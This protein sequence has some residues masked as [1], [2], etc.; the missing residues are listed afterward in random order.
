MQ[1]A[2]KVVGMAAVLG[3]LG[4]ASQASAGFTPPSSITPYLPAN[5][6][7]TVTVLLSNAKLTY[8]RCS[9]G[10][11]LT[12]ATGTP[13]S[14]VLVYGANNCAWANFQ[15][16]TVGAGA[17][18]SDVLTAQAW[19]NANIYFPYYAP[20]LNAAAKSA[21]KTAGSTPVAAPAAVSGAVRRR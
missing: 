12:V 1:Y 5:N 6:A 13:M 15:A 8:Y 10:G 17:S 11:V 7:V 4:F 3:L 20:L 14:A 19:Y 9:M 18:S 16:A 21:A 2:K